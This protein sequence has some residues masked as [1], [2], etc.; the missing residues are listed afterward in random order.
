M[1]PKRLAKVVQLLKEKYMLFWIS[2]THFCHLLSTL[3]L[4]TDH[5]RHRLRGWDTLNHPHGKLETCL[6]HA[7]IY[8]YKNSTVKEADA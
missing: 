1:T 3:A 8:A 5:R 2:K 7:L 4:R 6:S